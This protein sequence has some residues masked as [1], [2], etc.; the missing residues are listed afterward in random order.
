[1]VKICLVNARALWP[2]WS[3]H[4]AG[5]NVKLSNF[6]LEVGISDAILCVFRTH[7]ITCFLRID[8]VTLNIAVNKNFQ[9]IT[10]YK[11]TVVQLKRTRQWPPHYHITRIFNCIFIVQFYC[12]GQSTANT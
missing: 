2:V 11:Y 6:Y 8:G 1:M 7:W 3:L 5:V 12:F 9:I 10:Q 4:F